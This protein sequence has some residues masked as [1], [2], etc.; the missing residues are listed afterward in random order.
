MRRLIFEH[1][2]F[3]HMQ[4][5][6]ERRPDQHGN[7]EYESRITDIRTENT[8]S[9]KDEK[10]DQHLAVNVAEDDLGRQQSGNN[11]AED[12]VDPIEALGK[13]YSMHIF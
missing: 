4:F 3:R 5:S 11:D 9:G 13:I 8:A 10:L 12:S 7:R 6:N 2:F 1:P